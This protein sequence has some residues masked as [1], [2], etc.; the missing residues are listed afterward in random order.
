MK[1]PQITQKLNSLM[2]QELNEKKD[3]IS[4]IIDAYKSLGRVFDEFELICDLMAYS[5][6]DICQILGDLTSDLY[7]ELC[8]KFGSENV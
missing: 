7:S 5:L 8:L 4:C 2:I 6:G 3:A 1:N